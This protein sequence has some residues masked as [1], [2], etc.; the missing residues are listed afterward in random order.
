MELYNRIQ[1]VEK[2]ECNAAQD[3]MRMLV[4]PGWQNRLYYVAEDAK[5]FNKPFKDKY[6]NA[7]EAMRNNGIQ[8][9]S[10][11]NMDLTLIS[12]I[13]SYGFKFRPEI[14]TV[15]EETKNALS[16]LR[17]NKNSVSHSGHNETQEE[18]YLQSI[19]FLYHLK[20]FVRAVDEF[21]ISIPET[22]RLAFRQKYILRI[23]ELISELDEDRFELIYVKKS[24]EKNVQQV[25]KSTDKSRT[26]L[27]MHTLYSDRYFHFKKY[28][29][30]MENALNEKLLHEFDILSSSSGIVDAHSFA[31]NHLLHRDPQDAIQHIK[32]INPFTFDL[33]SGV[34]GTIQ[35][36]LLFYPESRDK[37]LPV[38]SVIEEKGYKVDETKPNCFNLKQINS[39][40]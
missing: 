10:I 28:N 2:I 16:V 18:I 17:N 26:W 36:I 33:A 37:Y 34:L 39:N 31:L 8:N 22:K 25:L 23:N 27:E 19:I 13:I 30:E 15:T 5:K 1:D 29:N 12:S 11:E 9:Y 35:D 40:N 14:S 4:S 3:F 20:Q 7:Y 21:E 6:I 24:I 38:I 32:L